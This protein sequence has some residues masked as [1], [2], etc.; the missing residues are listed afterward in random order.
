M[1]L[2][3]DIGGKT[4]L[5]LFEDSVGVVRETVHACAT[6]ARFNAKRR[7]RSWTRTLDVL[8][9]VE[10]RATIDAAQHAPAS[11]GHRA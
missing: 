3:G 9:G 1:I 2:A 10:P 4:V 8:V 6:L 11:K 5:A 7:F